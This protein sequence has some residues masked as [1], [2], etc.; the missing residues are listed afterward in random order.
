MP[1]I[2]ID[3]AEFENLLGIELHKDSEKIN[4]V[5]AFV[6]GEAKLFDEKEGT[7]SVEIKDTNRPDTWN[8]E[9]LVRAL[10]GFL[11]VEEGLKE[12]AVGKQSAEVYVDQRLENIRPY[13][14]C[15]IV[16]NL[17]LTDAAIRGFM[18]MQDKLDQTYGRNRRRTSIGLYN[19]DLIKL[20]L[21]YT[22]AK[23]NEVSF[24]P[25]GF[26]EKM[27][28]KQMLTQHPKGQEYG[29]I[30][31]KHPVYPI[32]LDAEDKPL[33][34]PPIINSNNLGRITEDTRNILVE[35]TGT[36]EEAVLNTLKIVTLSLIDR[37][38]K[39]HAA[40]IHYANRKLDT[41]TPNFDTCKMCLDVDY[42]NTVLGLQLTPRHISKLLLKA[43]Y[44]VE[45]HDR[46][47]VL[48]QIPCYRID[49][50]HPIDLVEDVAIAYDYNNIEPSWREMP[51]TGWV[52]PEQNMIDV[53][54]DLM[55]GLGF[56]EV[57][58]YTLTNPENLFKKMNCRK[59]RIVELSN[60]KV[61]TLTCLR[62]WLLPSLIEFTSNNLHVESPQKI[63]ELGKV[64][65]LDE[66][67]ETRTRDEDRLA[68]INYDANASFTEAKATIEAFMM[69]FGLEWQLKEVEHPSFIEGRAGKIMAKEKEVGILG[70]INPRVLEAW[71]LENPTAAFE[72]DIEKMVKIKQEEQ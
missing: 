30:V 9:G 11:G 56:Q 27:S 17:K 46:D 37:G 7:M 66:K 45:R 64:T 65:T 51:T 12:Y 8:V 23:P 68:A 6:K 69:N 14:G 43:G 44:G 28:L 1:T 5:L 33:S 18:H 13:I 54:R 71:K 70:E 21:Q 35:V 15:S 2:D 41:V 32:L 55:V 67:R 19:L 62:N 60:P 36:M 49:V 4:A 3:Y 57:L 26:T 72:L 42:T 25:L 61:I 48:V 63:F 39:A 16:K 53:A 58:T 47:R 29:H 22:V 59:E 10:R 31:M 50:M 34:F 52:R 24:V 20:P 40:K 38:G